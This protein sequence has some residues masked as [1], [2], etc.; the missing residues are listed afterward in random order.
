MSNPI[1]GW[2]VGLR[3]CC[4]EQ[5]SYYF[6]SEKEIL[7]NGERTTTAS[8]GERAGG[9]ISQNLYGLGLF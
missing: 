3:D 1:K 7:H 9:L 8:G 4:F 6:A 2:T 5:R